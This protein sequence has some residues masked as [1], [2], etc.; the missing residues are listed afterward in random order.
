[1]TK[2]YKKETDIYGKEL[3]LRYMD[4]IVEAFIP[5]DP[6]NTDYQEYLA[7]LENEGIQNGQS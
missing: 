7:S 5:I 3:I 1:M 2:T 4:E 6:A